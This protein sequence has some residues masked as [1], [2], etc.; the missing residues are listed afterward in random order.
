LLGHDRSSL[1]CGRC[2]SQRGILADEE[3][4][5]PPPG[6]SRA[7]FL[8]E[9]VNPKN[10]G[11]LP[12]NL[13]PDQTFAKGGHHSFTYTDYMLSK[14]FRNSRQLVGCDDCHDAMGDKA[15]DG[16]TYRYFLKGDPD[17]SSTSSSLCMK[18]HAIDVNAHVTQKTGSVMMGQSMKC[19][20]CHMQRTGKA[21]A[22]RPGLLLGTPT[23]ITTDANITYWEGDQSAHNWFVPRKFDPGIAGVVPGSAMPS[24]YTNSCGTCHDASKLPFQAAGSSPSASAP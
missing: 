12:A 16:V 24:P 2:H 21:A 6:I 15:A 10:K 18:C 4:A 9:F 5:F 19:I 17:D 22:G 23:G 14:H 1:I 11:P 7:Q 20:Q 13:W 8:A 3:G